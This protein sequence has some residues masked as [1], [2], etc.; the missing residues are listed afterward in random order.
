MSARKLLRRRLE[1]AAE[2]IREELWAD[3]W[4]GRPSFLRITAPG[5]GILDA[6]EPKHLLSLQPGERR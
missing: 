4:Y 1:R 2:R 5:R 6:N 3:V